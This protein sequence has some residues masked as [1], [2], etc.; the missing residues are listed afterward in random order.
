MWRNITWIFIGLHDCGMVVIM[1][2]YIFFGS[3]YKPPTGSLVPV[4]IT[5][6]DHI[7]LE[8]HYPRETFL[9]KYR[10]MVLCFG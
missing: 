2:V 4:T 10:T 5:V 1:Y 6:F 8:G 7:M 9:V 3:Y